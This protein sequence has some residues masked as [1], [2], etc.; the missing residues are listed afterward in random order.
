[1]VGAREATGATA[2]SPRMCG[3]RRLRRSGE[4]EATRARWCRLWLRLCVLLSA[5]LCCFCSVLRASTGVCVCG[6]VCVMCQ[7]C[8][9]SVFWHI[10]LGRV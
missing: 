8:D 7:W 2:I 3:L 1:M 5:P 6:C 10:K 9:A 4:M